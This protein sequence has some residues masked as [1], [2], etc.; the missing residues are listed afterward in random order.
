MMASRAARKGSRTERSATHRPLILTPNEVAD[1]LLV[2]PVT[3]RLWAS[4]GLL[5]SVSTP[6]GHRR[7]RVEDVDAF[8]E[9]RKQVQGAAHHR[10]SR[11]LIIDDDAQFTRYLSNLLAVRAP[12]LAVDVAHD[13]FSAG[14]KCESM[15]PDI[16]TLDIHMPDMDGFA[17]CRLLRSMFG[18]QKPRLVALTGFPSRENVAQMLEAGANACLPKTTPADQLIRELGLAAIAPPLPEP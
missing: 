17:V 12:W 16:V 10:P 7:F 18:E 13:G 6:G 15:R 9:W 1:R 3:V 8:I 2:A 4:K 14:I 11:L 5:P